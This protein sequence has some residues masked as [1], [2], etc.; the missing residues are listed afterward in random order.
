MDKPRAE[1]AIDEFLRALGRDPDAEPE[2]RQ[3]KSRVAAAFAEQ[4]C[5]GYTQ[6]PR[7]EIARH[8]IEG[9]R[10]EVIVRDIPVL[11]TCPH[12]L[13]LA[14]GTASVG[15]LAQGK[16]VGLGA[17]ADVV[18]I[19]SRR[20]VLQE[21]IGEEV[22]RAIFDALS[23]AWVFCRL[24]LSHGCMRVADPALSQTTVETLATRGDV[25]PL[26]ARDGHGTASRAEGDGA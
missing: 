4:L 17:I 18:R 3:T 11:T 1:R 21:E 7:A 20:L 9:V 2:L 26:A 23:P 25:P 6:D 13:M 16:G 8:L 19:C 15:F 10:G 22:C 14:T 24:T 5:A 12:H